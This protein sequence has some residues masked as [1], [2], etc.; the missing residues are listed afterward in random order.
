MSER[1]L[2]TIG[3]GVGVRLGTYG[4]DLR[5]YEDRVEYH[6][7]AMISRG[8][9]QTIRH[10][11]IAQVAVLRGIAYSSLSVQSV[12]GGGFTATG[13][14]KSEADRAKALIDKLVAQARTGSAPANDKANLADQLAQLSTLHEAGSLTD[15]EFAAAKSQLLNP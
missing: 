1:P 4:A 11:D 3:Q 12:G 2:L 9:T 15:E 6:Q 7:N 8:L 10:T 13:V 14:R 5:I